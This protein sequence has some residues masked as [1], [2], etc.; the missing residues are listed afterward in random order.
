MQSETLKYKNPKHQSLQ[1]CSV[2]VYIVKGFRARA[3]QVVLEQNK[4]AC[5]IIGNNIW[6]E[7]AAKLKKTSN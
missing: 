2:E 1:C 4:N 6:L 7:R 3:F 5:R